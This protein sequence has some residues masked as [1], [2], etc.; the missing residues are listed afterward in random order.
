MGI[1]G[2]RA[3]LI[4]TLIQNAKRY[5]PS[6][7]VGQLDTVRDYVLVNDIGKFVA[8]C[9]NMRAERPES[10]LLASGRPTAIGEVLDI[11]GKVIGRPLYLKLDTAP[12]NASHFSYRRSA[13]PDNWFPTDLETGIKQ[14]ARQLASSF[15][16]RG[17]T[18]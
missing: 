15:E 7:I 11:V 10:F 17:M 18:R 6:R 16:T 3:G 2:G 1:F 13:L 14:V 5:T 8:H 9:M 4:A 12:S